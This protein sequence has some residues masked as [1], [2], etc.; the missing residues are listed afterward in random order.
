[1]PEKKDDQ[2]RTERATPR[3]REEARKKGQV[4]RSREVV[5]AAVLSAC[6]ICFY[7]QSSGVMERLMS[8]MRS[9][10]RRSTVFT[11]SADTVPALFA[12]TVLE[13]LILLAPFF[14]T[15]VLAGLAA[16]AFQ[17]GFRITAESVTPKL[18][19]INPLEGFKRLFSLQ[20]V[21]ELVKSVIKLA[22]IGFVA[23]LSVRSELPHLVPL[24]DQSVP[25]IVRFMGRV[26]FRILGTTC[27]ILAVLA[28]L[29]YAYQRWEHER[30]LR[31]SRQ[32]IKDETKETEGDPLI[33]SRIRRIQ[34]E[35]ARRRMMAAVPKADVVITNPT[36]LAVALRYDPERMAAPTVVAKGKGFLAATIREVAERHGVPVVENKPVAQV[37]YKMVDVSGIIPENLYKAVAEILAFVYKL[38]E[39][40]S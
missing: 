32:E 18:S 13:M 10:F 11:L 1:M 2:E 8:M 30:N 19:K 9:S 26:S 15:V 23:Y 3:K 34:Q 24:M 28:V 14:L 27:V 40:A 7:F 33:K 39:N 12:Q 16:N 25:D 38:R 22:I 36:H 35:M 17:V 5:S 31:M 29:D 4:A 6:L 37:L 20:S 21:M